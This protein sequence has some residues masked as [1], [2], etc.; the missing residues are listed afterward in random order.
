M[1][2]GF[3]ST[4]FHTM[5]YVKSN[6]KTS[7]LQVLSQL[8]LTQSHWQ[9][10]KPGRGWFPKW[11]D[12]GCYHKS[13]KL[14]KPQWQDIQKWS[15]K[16]TLKKKKNSLSKT[17]TYYSLHM[18]VCTGVLLKRIGGSAP[19]HQLAGSWGAFLTSPYSPLP[20]QLQHLL[21]HPKRL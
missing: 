11:L 15:A 5:D 3:C 13:E 21:S 9:K 18:H 7:G 1:E 2:K 10:T 16:F 19:E 20:H 8:A 6:N 17:L 14:P 4:L 12:S